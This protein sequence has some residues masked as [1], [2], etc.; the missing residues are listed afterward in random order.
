MA[1]TPG[2]WV[3]NYDPDDDERPLEIATAADRDHR[4]AFTASNGNPADSTLL[5]AG[6][7]LLATLKDG[8]SLAGGWREAIVELEDWCHERVR[9]KN[10]LAAADQLDR[11]AKAARDAI[12]KAEA[13]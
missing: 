11:W 2:P 3:V 10:M 12:D 4:V 5:A 8:L 6:P 13:A 1:H 9:L 7:E